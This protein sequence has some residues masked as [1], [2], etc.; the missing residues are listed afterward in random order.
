MIIKYHKAIADTGGVI[1]DEISDKVVG[2]LIPD[3][4]TQEMLDGIDIF[5]KI[6]I[7]N[8]GT[9]G[10]INV[11][12]S[13]LGAFNA[14]FFPS[15]GDAQVIGDL[16]GSEDRLGTSMIS[17]AIDTGSTEETSNGS[18]GLIDIKKIIV[19]KNA[20]F[21][22]FRIGENIMIGRYIA[23]ISAVIDL[24][25]DWEITLLSEIPYI[26]TIGTYASSSDEVIIEAGSHAS[27][28]MQIHIEPSSVIPDHFSTV[29]I[30]TIKSET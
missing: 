18:G 6:Y 16:T 1:G 21:S 30:K 13:T 10:T 12:I 9:S 20:D 7:K 24:V 11:G 8:T 26:Y 4:D 29:N 5:R 2:A 3:I 28:W 25:T 27:Y 22:F 19:S 23:E 14:S 15:T 17:K